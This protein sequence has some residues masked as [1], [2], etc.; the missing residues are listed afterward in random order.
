MLLVEWLEVLV[1]ESHVSKSNFLAHLESCSQTFLCDER[2]KFLI[3]I[4]VDSAMIPFSCTFSPE[5]AAELREWW[6][7]NLVFAGRDADTI[8]HC[9]W[10]SLFKAKDQICIPA[11]T[12]TNASVKS[13]LAF[14]LAERQHYR[15]A[16]FVLSTCL[17][18]T[19]DTW[20]TDSPTRH[21]LLTE[22]VNCNNMLGD[23]AQAESAARQALQRSHIDNR[24]DIACLKIALA[25]SYI[26]QCKYEMA[27]EVLT[28]IAEYKSLSNDVL[29]RIAL[30][31]TKAKRR[32]AREAEIPIVNIV[33]TNLIERFIDAQE[34]IPESLRMECLEETLFVVVNA[35]RPVA[36][37]LTAGDVPPT[38]ELIEAHLAGA[39]NNWRIDAIRKALDSSNPL[40]FEDGDENPISDDTLLQA[41]GQAWA[42]DDDAYLNKPPPQTPTKAW[43]ENVPE[44]GLVAL[45]SG[46]YQMSHELIIR[47]FTIGN[48]DLRDRV[49]ELSGPVMYK[50]SF[51][52]SERPRTADVTSA[53]STI[54]I[55]YRVESEWSKADN[56]DFAIVKCYVR[57]QSLHKSH[58]S[59]IIS[60]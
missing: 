17:S 8:S 39:S 55:S 21:L 41:L 28:E 44:S 60:F 46:P 24:F 37:A 14:A 49:R 11:L 1:F 6:T 22:F 30:R 59:T 16:Q 34:N 53:F 33:N 38:H 2:L 56:V 43:D 58:A 25:D 7:A 18:D 32:L 3:L 45:P 42:W 10:Q 5:I 29:L 36:D 51:V 54:N 15:Q 40:P 27:I 13:A 4:N 52:P 23:Q 20:P 48:S 35:G 9:L 47:V 50:G 57:V 31:L 26:G 19:H 12:T